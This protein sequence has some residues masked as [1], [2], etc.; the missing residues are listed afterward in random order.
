MSKSRLVSIVRASM[1]VIATSSIGA[2]IGLYVG[3][4]PYAIPATIGGLTGCGIGLWLS[5]DNI[6]NI[7]Y[8]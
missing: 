4:E 3:G 7:F 1:P 5:F 6:V 8:S 2:G